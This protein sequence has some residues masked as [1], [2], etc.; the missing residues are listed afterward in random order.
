M[1]TW[2]ENCGKKGGGKGLE[3]L[4]GSGSGGGCGPFIKMLY[5]LYASPI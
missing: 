4:E 2:K 1:E 3:N 5:S